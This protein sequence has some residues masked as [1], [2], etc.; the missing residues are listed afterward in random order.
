MLAELALAVHLFLTDT[1]SY[2]A[3]FFVLNPFLLELSC[4]LA[5]L[6][7]VLLTLLTELAVTVMVAFTKDFSY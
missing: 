1:R 7:L 5:E 2:R 3:A 4:F 6:P